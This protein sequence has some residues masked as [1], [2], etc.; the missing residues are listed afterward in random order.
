MDNKPSLSEKCNQP[1]LFEFEGYVIRPFDGWNLWMEN[2]IGEGTTISKLEWLA[3]LAKLF[4][5]NF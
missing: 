2:P 1:A 4:E 3:T 5:R